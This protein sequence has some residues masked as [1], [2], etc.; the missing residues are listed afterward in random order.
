MEG[1][2]AASCTVWIVA[3]TSSLLSAEVTFL[4][5]YNN[6]LC[7]CVHHLRHTV[8]VFEIAGP[9]LGTVA[10]KAQTM[11]LYFIEAFLYTWDKEDNLCSYPSPIFQ[12]VFVDL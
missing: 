8:S 4:K 10:T 9:L 1:L 12:E 6:A 11:F 2:N 3:N 7:D 5:L